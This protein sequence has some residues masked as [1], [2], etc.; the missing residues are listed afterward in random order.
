MVTIIVLTIFIIIV[1]IWIII[2]RTN[3]NYQPIERLIEKAERSVIL[4]QIDNKEFRSKSFKKV[5]TNEKIM[6]QVSSLGLQ[7]FDPDIYMH[8]KRVYFHGQNSYKH[9]WGLSVNLPAKLRTVIIQEKYNQFV[10]RVNR[11]VLWQKWEHILVSVF[12]VLYPP[13][14]LLFMHRFRRNRAH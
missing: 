4:N 11:T 6:I 12:D 9:P 13:L 8:M 14:G 1:M 5:M 10:S 3:S 7:F 2:Q